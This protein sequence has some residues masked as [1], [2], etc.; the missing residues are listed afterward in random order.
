MSDDITVKHVPL[1]PGER[2][3]TGE[4]L[5]ALGLRLVTCDKAGNEI[6]ERDLHHYT[7]DK[8]DRLVVIY[9]TPL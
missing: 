7:G 3:R 8:H 2:S 5:I 9:M 4:H 1:K 6:D